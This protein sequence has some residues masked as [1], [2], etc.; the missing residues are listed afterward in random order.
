MDAIN[1]YYNGHSF[2]PIK[3]VQ[4]KKNQKAIVTIIDENLA[5]D[6]AAQLKGMFAGSGM[7]SEKFASQKQFEK[8][9]EL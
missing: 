4:A 5:R 1:A 9:L 8:E 7:S 6:A 2:V 3:P